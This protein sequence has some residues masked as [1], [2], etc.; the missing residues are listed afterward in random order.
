[1]TDNIHSKW[2][3]WTFINQYQFSYVMELNKLLHFAELNYLIL[4]HVP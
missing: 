3:T 4:M 2:D 1:M